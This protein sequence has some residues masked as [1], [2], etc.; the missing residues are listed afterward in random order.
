MKLRADRLGVVAENLRVLS[1]TDA[2]KVLHAAEALAPAAVAVDSIQ[3]QYLP[4]RR[5]RP[6]P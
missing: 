1:E 6:A 4:G 3:T 2:N 5:A